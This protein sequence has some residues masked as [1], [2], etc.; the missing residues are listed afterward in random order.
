MQLLW[1]GPGNRKDSRTAIS[2]QGNSSAIIIAYASELIMLL[3][4]KRELFIRERVTKVIAV[5]K[6]IDIKNWCHISKTKWLRQKHNWK[7]SDFDNY[8]VYRW[9]AFDGW[10]L[11]PYQISYYYT[12]N[13]EI[14]DVGKTQKN[15]AGLKYFR[16]ITSLPL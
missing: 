15:V 5:I 1:S 4:I 13:Q 6:R 3:H 16:V 14:L 8:E 10:I 2:C 12:K 9:F 7:N 11:Q